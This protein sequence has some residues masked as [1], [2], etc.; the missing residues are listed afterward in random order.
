LE[1]A[2]DEIIVGLEA[3]RELAGRLQSRID[4]AWQ[5]FRDDAGAASGVDHDPSNAL[6]T[7]PMPR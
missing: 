3:Y 1:H 4:I 6:P 2:A 7:A 5:G